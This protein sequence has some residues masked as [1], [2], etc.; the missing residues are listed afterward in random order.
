MQKK[1]DGVQYSGSGSQEEI[2]RRL[3]LGPRLLR[4][5]LLTFMTVVALHILNSTSFAGL[6]EPV[7]AVPIP[8]AVMLLFFIDLICRNDL[9][10]S[11]SYQPKKPNKYQ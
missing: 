2:C 10:T 7:G 11:F 6:L 9:F 1:T 5:G 3:E 4:F 8:K